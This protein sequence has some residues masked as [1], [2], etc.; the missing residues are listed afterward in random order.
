VWHK[1]L[2][3]LPLSQ[4]A[5]ISVLSE[6]WLDGS[7]SFAAWKAI[8][9]AAN[10]GEPKKKYRSHMALVCVHS[11]WICDRCYSHKAG[12]ERPSDIP[13][14][15]ADD[16][17][18]GLIWSLCRDCR[19]Q[20][21]KK[22]PEPL[23]ENDAGAYEFRMHK[24]P[25]TDAFYNYSFT[26]TDL[27]DLHCDVRRNPYKRLGT[28]MRL[29]RTY[30]LQKR[31]LELHGGW[32]G[33]DCC[34]NKVAR[35][36]N[37]AFTIREKGRD[38]SAAK[39]KGKGKDDNKNKQGVDNAGVAEGNQNQDETSR[40]NQDETNRQGQGTSR[41]QLEDG[42]NVDNSIAGTNRCAAL[43][44]IA[45]DIAGPLAIENEVQNAIQVQV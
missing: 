31:A 16:D 30:E 3:L 24:M 35:S 26:E 27:R 5:R 36:R 28:P 4:V 6:T 25:K 9:Q 17:D 33:V 20:Y 22:H 7:R 34:K 45:G 11:F 2:S 1:I 15:M 32:I 39:G 38:P 41:E 42:S 37:R 43:N 18:N 21:Y 29:Y 14:A 8:C 40:A 44:A 10:L 19:L 13:L 12:R 23:R